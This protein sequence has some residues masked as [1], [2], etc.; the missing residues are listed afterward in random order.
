VLNLPA[1]RA[2]LALLAGL[3]VAESTLTGADSPP[4]FNRDIA[5]ILFRHCTPCHRPGAAGPFPLLTFA[6][7]QPRAQ[8]LA[9]AVASQ[10]MPPWMPE[11]GHGEYLGERR[12]S[13]EEVVAIQ[14]W[15]TAGAPE[16][17]PEDRPTPPDFAGEWQLGAPD[18]I[19]TLPESFALEPAGRDVYRN[20]VVP[21]PPGTNRFV[22]AFEFRPESPAVHHAR[23]LFDMSGESRRRD[24]ADPVCGF[25][26][27]MPPAQF[28][29]GQMLGWVPGRGATIT[30]EG[31]PWALDG[32]GDLV[33]QLHLQRTGRPETIRPRLGLYITNR[34]PTKSP[35]LLG[36]LAQTMDIPAGAT[37]YTVVRTAQ[38]P[39]EADLLAVLP[40]AHYLA[41]EVE[42]SAT[43]PGEA[44]RS[45]L[46]IRNWKFNWQDEYRYARPMTLPAGT[47][48]EMRIT[49]DNSAANPNNPHSPPRRVL[50]GPDSTDEMGELWLQLLPRNSVGYA[51][52]RKLQRELSQQEIAADFFVRLEREP[53][54]AA[55]R[56]EL[57][58]ALGSLGRQREAFEQLTRAV[59]LNPNLAEAHQYIGIS[60]LER[61]LFDDAR[62]AL[63]QALSLNPRLHR[64]HLALGL[65]AEA[66]GD[67]AEAERRLTRAVELN[68][69]D[70]AVRRKLAGIRQQ[71]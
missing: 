28:P 26:G 70:E 47:R 31:M 5:P 19:V 56:L 54:N 36:L 45:L 33:I 16:G 62:P 60:F 18:L 20:F 71:K 4:T 66:E 8:K 1:S 61:R 3:T 17:R 9:T 37:T 23:I 21:L 49:Y 34:P 52:L 39:A 46:L 57:G 32:A 38:L 22:R 42:F 14:R 67:L 15:A 29:P 43:P 58:K 11:R 41:R 13:G 64:S 27:T 24:D 68:P 59:E 48:L 50:H 69:T 7:A 35:V 44:P 40:H 2:G 55:Y 12:L 6:D 65:I 10:E 63:E 51:V 25:G 53:D 30:P